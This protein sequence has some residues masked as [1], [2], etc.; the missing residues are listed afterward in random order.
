MD[1]IQ[2]ANKLKS[3]NDNVL[4]GVIDLMQ[5]QLIEMD[6]REFAEVSA[7]IDD[8]KKKINEA[9]NLAMALA[10]KG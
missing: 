3:M 9:C 6:I 8:A 4:S 10:K 2:Q 1:K 7:M 5:E